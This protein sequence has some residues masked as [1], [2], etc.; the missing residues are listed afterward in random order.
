M[1][2][3]LKIEILNGLISQPQIGICNRV[4]DWYSGQVRWIRGFFVSLIGLGLPGV[5][6]C[7][8]HFSYDHSALK[9]DHGIE[10]V[11]IQP[12]QN[13]TMR[14][15]LD[16]VFWPILQQGFAQDQRVTIVAQK[17]QAQGVLKVIIQDFQVRGAADTAVGRLV[18]HAI[19]QQLPASGFVVSTSFVAT[20]SCK[21]E[22]WQERLQEKLQEKQTGPASG[23]DASGNFAR[24]VWENT[25]NRQQIFASSIQ[26]DVVGATSATIHDGETTRAAGQIAALMVQEARE[27]MIS[28]F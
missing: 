19:S 20:M 7:G 18:P 24:L 5:M 27:S 13:T 16:E 14:A 11:F 6:G 17:S 1:G 12:I 4:Q 21:F 2:Q 23:G 3:V 9:Q 22:L 26:V 28:L 15:G 10:L 25:F 8:Y